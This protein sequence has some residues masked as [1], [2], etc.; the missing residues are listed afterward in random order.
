MKTITTQQA[1]DKAMEDI[2]NMTP[3]RLRENLHNYNSLLNRYIRESGKLNKEDPIH[4]IPEGQHPENISIYNLAKELAKTR[5]LKRLEILKDR[6]KLTLLNYT[7]E[8]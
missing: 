3:K 7:Y 1:T 4:T 2:N 8:H 6:I 5:D